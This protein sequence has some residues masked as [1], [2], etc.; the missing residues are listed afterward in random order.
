MV[1]SYS[2]F[3]LQGLSE[4]PRQIPSLHINPSFITLVTSVFHTALSVRPILH[5]CRLQALLTF[6]SS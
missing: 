6:A 1:N 5:A 3:T 2:V 4:M